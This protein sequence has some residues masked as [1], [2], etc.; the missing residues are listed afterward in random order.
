MM[1]LY[2]CKPFGPNDYI[3]LMLVTR[4]MWQTMCKSIGRAELIEDSR[5]KTGKDRRAN[6]EALI[7]EISRWTR[8]RTKYEA[9][10]ELA[11]A[12]VPCSAVLDTRDLFEDPH[13]RERGF[14]HEIDHPE[15]GRVPLL[16]WPA[17]LSKSQVP[18]TPSPELGAH[19]EAV[20]GADLGLDEDELRKLRERG[21]FG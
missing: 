5:F 16:G 11:E 17:R 10:R 12:G 13:L 9:M 18:I 4:P 20:L 7:E 14:I 1:N 19:T 6:G 3:Y 15:L 2:A 8:E 21:A